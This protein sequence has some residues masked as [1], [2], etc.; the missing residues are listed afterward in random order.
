MTQFI[1]I[2]IYM[3]HQAL[4]GEENHAYSTAMINQNLEVIVS[5]SL[6]R[7]KYDCIGLCHS[8]RNAAIQTT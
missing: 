1:D 3:P 4:L 8:M 5:I 6:P 2:Y 7:G